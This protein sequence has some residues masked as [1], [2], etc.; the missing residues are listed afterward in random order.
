MGTD[1]RQGDQGDYCNILGGK[2]VMQDWR[3]NGE[4]EVVDWESYFTF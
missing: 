4:R 2:K 1:W 3:E